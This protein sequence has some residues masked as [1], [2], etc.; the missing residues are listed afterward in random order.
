[1]LV[2]IDRVSGNTENA[3]RW[4]SNFAGIKKGSSNDKN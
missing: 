3:L 4:I 2:V 1:M